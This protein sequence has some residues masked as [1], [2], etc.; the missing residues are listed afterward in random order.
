LVAFFCKFIFYFWWNWSIIRI[1]MYLSTRISRLCKRSHFFSLSLHICVCVCVCW[2]GI[3]ELVL[4]VCVCVGGGHDGGI[5]PLLDLKIISYFPY[6]LLFFDD[7]PPPCNSYKAAPISSSLCNV[8]VCVCVCVFVR[9]CLW[10]STS[11]LLI[12]TGLPNFLDYW[13]LCIN[14]Y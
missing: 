11:V 13:Y 2:I 14:I 12:L 7:I 10:L 1:Y 4:C 3:S 8:Y 5:I 6:L 9:V